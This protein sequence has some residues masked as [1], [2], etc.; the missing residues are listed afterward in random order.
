[1]EIRIQSHCFPRA[2]KVLGNLEYKKANIEGTAAHV[3]VTSIPT[4]L[5]GLLLPENRSY[6]A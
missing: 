3:Q 4:L 6:S 5:I 1:M 2:P